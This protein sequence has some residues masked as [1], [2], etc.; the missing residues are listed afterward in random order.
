[1]ARLSAQD[2]YRQLTG[3]GFS[4]PAAT[5]GTAVALAQ[6]GGD[7]AAATG[8][9]DATWGPPYGLWGIRTLKAD[10]GRGT[11]RDVVTLAGDDAA[12]AQA[13][14]A[15]SRGGLNWGP[16]AAYTTGAYRAYLGQAQA[17]AGQAPDIGATITGGLLGA[18]GLSPGAVLGGVRSIAVEALVLGLGVGLLALGVWRFAG[19]SIRAGARRA[20]AVAAAAAI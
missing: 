12:Q 10:T 4:P 6:S 17:A 2:I 13:A 1:M 5:V 7:D 16:W 20:G 3:A 8:P 19:P 15:I 9:G 18:A 14:Y 11:A